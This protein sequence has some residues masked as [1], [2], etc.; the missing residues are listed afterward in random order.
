MGKSHVMKLMLTGC[1][2]S[3]PHQVQA[4]RSELVNSEHWHGHEHGGSNGHSAPAH[5]VGKLCTMKLQVVLMG[6]MWSTQVAAAWGMVRMTRASRV[7]LVMVLSFGL[8]SRD[9][10]IIISLL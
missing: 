1:M 8:L 4:V 9:V 6:H 7:L 10:N 2:W 3:T 5:A